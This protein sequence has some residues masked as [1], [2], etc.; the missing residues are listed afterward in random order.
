MKHYYRDDNN[1]LEAPTLEEL[2][3]DLV[4]YHFET[5]QQTIYCNNIYY[6]NT[7]TFSN[8]AKFLRALDR[9]IKTINNQDY[10]LSIKYNG[11]ETTI[12]ICFA[13]CQ[14]VVDRFTIEAQ[15]ELDRAYQEIGGKF[16]E[17]GEL[18]YDRGI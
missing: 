10:D 5:D 16:N 13:I 8:K 4:D 9:V 2:K 1:N 18:I 14:K 11:E 17:G 6:N 15:E 7:L 12:D 3:K